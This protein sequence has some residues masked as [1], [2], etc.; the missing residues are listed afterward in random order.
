[1]SYKIKTA[2]SLLW[3]VMDEKLGKLMKESLSPN[4]H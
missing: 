1:M 2:S 4:K 3:K